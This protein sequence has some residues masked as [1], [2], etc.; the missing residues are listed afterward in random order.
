VLAAA[1]QADTVIFVGGNHPQGDR[2]W[3]EVAVPTD[4]KEAVDRESID[5]Q[6][7]DL[8]R[9]TYRANAN[10]I[11]VLVSNFPI[12]VTWA[13]LHLPA[14]VHMSHNSQELGNALA[15]VLFGDVN[16]GGRLSQTWP[17][18]IAQLPPM[19]DYDIR[20]GRTYM[21]FKGLPLYAF[22][23]GLSYTSFAYKNLRLNNP[24]VAADGEIL[25]TVD[26]TNSGKAAG[27]EVVQMYVRY[28]GSAV[29]RAQL[30]LRGFK[31]VTLQPG[32]TQAVQ[33]SLRGK[34][35][36]YWDSLAQAWAVEPGQIEILVGPSSDRL[37]LRLRV[38][39][40]P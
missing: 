21:Y 2:G 13:D 27:D 32:E 15:G 36:A 16:P 7:E 30:Q 23:Y 10:T 1:A 29:E 17:R 26:V 4:G 33:I 9:K 12:A 31:R 25:V 28:P 14:I 34:D 22:G 8:L 40:Q 37:P 19:L 24:A 3:A 11:L 39:V 6:Q 20:K 5:L 35:L 18:S 38:G